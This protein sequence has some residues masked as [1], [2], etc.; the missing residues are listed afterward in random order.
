MR[1]AGIREARQRLS[2]LIDEVR[3]G[4]EILL[5]DRGRAVA[6]IVPPRLSSARPYRDHSRFRSS[7]R[8]KGRPLSQTVAAGRED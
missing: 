2:T 3:K 4:R 8:L 1:T 7:V 6:R 5:T